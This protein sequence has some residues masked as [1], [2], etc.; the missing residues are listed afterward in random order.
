MS[1][2][3]RLLLSFGG[4]ILF[5]VLIAVVGAF[6]LRQVLAD[7][8]DVDVDPLGKAVKLSMLRD[9]LSDE[10]RYAVYVALTT[11]EDYLAF[12][13]KKISELRKNEDSVLADLNASVKTPQGLKSLDLINKA[14]PQYRS[15]IDDIDKAAKSK[16]KDAAFDLIMEDVR[17]SQNRVQIAI[18]DLRKYEIAEAER[19]DTL[20]I[21]TAQRGTYLMIG[22]SVAMAVFGML[23]SLAVARN[24][25]RTLGGEPNEMGEQ[26]Q[27]LAAGHLRDQDDAQAP[28]VPNS[29]LD[30]LRQIQRTLRLYIHAQSE[31]A[32]RH[33]QGQVDARIDSA[34]L[35]GAYGEMASASNALVD[36][37]VRLTFRLVE[38][39]D[40]Y[41]QGKFAQ[42]IE[43]LPGQQKRITESVEAARD[44]MQSA[45]EAAVYN[46]RV[47]NALNKAS[48]Q[49][50]IADAQHVILFMNEPARRL[51]QDHSGEFQQRVSG[52]D[53]A[54]LIG[55]GIAG[56]HPELERHAA[57]LDV[58]NSEQTVDLQVG[59]MHLVVTMNA[60][61]G[62]DGALLGSVIE[63]QDRTA[64]VLV[65][66]ELADAV[67]KA[68]A[69]DFSLRLVQDGKTGFFAA[70]ST[71]MNRLLATS[72]QGLTDVSELLAAF[73][74]GDLSG[75]IKRDYQGLFGKVKDSAN[76]T[77]ENLTRVMGEVREAADALT[78][79]ADQVS[80]TAQ[81]LSQAASEQAA[82][83][84]ETSA[85]VETMSASISQ[86]S[87]NA[88]ITDGVATKASKEASDGGTAVNLTLEA[89]K[90]IAQKIGIVDDI[91]YQTNLLALNAAIEAARA[92]EHG[93]GFA[94]VAAEVRKLAERSQEAAKEIGELAAN[95]VTTAERAGKLLDSIVPSI[96]KTS[97]LVQEITAASTE[98][99]E[100]VVHIGGAMG[101]LSK[102]TQQNASA[103]EQLAATSEELSGQAAQL[104]Q[105]VAFF[106]TGDVTVRDQSKLAH[107][108]AAA[109]TD[110]RSQSVAT[111]APRQ[112]L[113]IG[114][115]NFKPY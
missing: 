20:K 38:L 89:M 112:T 29:L 12:A 73:A 51:L 19:S 36:S 48:T 42:H 91:A 61:S 60:I 35:P 57:M 107:R 102:A 44:T 8:P 69:G 37:H 6:S 23:I 24:V 77:A 86:N 64:E 14:Y 17:T 103:S 56:L 114:S 106:K 81:S 110:R 111:L 59:K 41:A 82:S 83:V 28:A 87:D 7:N 98:Q 66:R 45:A 9:G 88:K 113:A 55:Q 49:V 74:E 72:E 109:P 50:L 13:E 67:G 1:L 101:Q 5:G 16:K 25:M 108:K 84:E 3:L 70:L 105:S 58:Q 30:K 71:D 76:T 31:M 65:Q 11:D 115:G 22:L 99:S 10:S 90:Q 63:L 95:S 4:V 68:A 34:G 104:Q 100:S 43:A 39:L 52:F 94:V 85:Q 62:T 26:M 40:G 75:R 18:Q 46:M 53:P 21:Q 97:D 2:R 79:A 27:R 32:Q 96:Q 78:V 15:D 33:A 93:K 47:V 92:G 80:A 54:R